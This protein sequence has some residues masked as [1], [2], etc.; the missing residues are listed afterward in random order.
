MLNPK[1][2]EH[3]NV[4]VQVATS[5]ARFLAVMIFHE[6][7]SK[8]TKMGSSQKLRCSEHSST[9]LHLNKVY[10]QRHKRHSA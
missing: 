9:A 5:F 10:Y 8:Y 1:R 3:A 2:A 6:C 4:L 7:F